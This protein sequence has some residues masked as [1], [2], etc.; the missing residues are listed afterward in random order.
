MG[1]YQTSY[2]QHPA[3]REEAAL[4]GGRQAT[5]DS[6]LKFRAGKLYRDACE[7]CLGVQHI[8]LDG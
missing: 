5:D 4:A 3:T 2:L 6:S 1:G 8:S 7:R